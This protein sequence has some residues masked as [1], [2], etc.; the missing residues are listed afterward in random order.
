MQMDRSVLQVKFRF[1]GCLVNVNALV[2]GNMA[3]SLSSQL[4]VLVFTKQPSAEIFSKCFFARIFGELLENSSSASKYFPKSF[5][6]FTKI[7]P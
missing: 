7:H 5:R 3:L 6:N 2:L 4:I 1:M